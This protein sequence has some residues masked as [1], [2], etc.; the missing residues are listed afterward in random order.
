MPMLSLLR[1]RR[2]LGFTLFVLATMTVCVLMARWQWSRYQVRLA[3]NDRL[4]AALSAPA[5]PIAEVLTAEAAG[6]DLRTFP[7]DLGWRSVSA[8]GVFDVRHEAAV[9]RRPQDGRNGFWIVT[10]LI[11]DHGVLLVNRGWVAASG[12]ALTSPDVAPPPAGPVTVVGRLRPPEVSTTSDQ[13]PPGQ[14]WAADPQALIQPAGVPR[15]AAYVVLTGSQP[16]SSAGLTPLPEP[17]HRGAN[18]LAYF[19]QWALFGLVGLVGWWRLLAG[20]SAGLRRGTA[21][22]PVSASA[23]PVT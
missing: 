18:N 10:P 7:A 20:E 9:R 17:G 6:R 16:T 13:A 3:E 8:R 12:D 2:W 1:Q 21:E 23:H 11:T 4:D 22:E 15:Y 14:A 5:V 19:V